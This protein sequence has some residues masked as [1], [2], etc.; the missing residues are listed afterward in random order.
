LYIFLSGIADISY[1][2][3][4]EE[5]DEDILIKPATNERFYISYENTLLNEDDVL[6]ERGIYEESELI[7]SWDEYEYVLKLTAKLRKQSD[8]FA[9]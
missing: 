8:F 5:I 4:R 2:A 6:I 1:Y 7:V 3:Y 9:E